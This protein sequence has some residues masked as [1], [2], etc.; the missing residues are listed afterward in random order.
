MLDL[1]PVKAAMYAPT[2]VALRTSSTRRAGSGYRQTSARYYISRKY[3]H[4]VVYGHGLQ[5]HVD[6]ALT[7]E[8]SVRAS[9]S[10]LGGEF[11]PVRHNI[12]APHPHPRRTVAARIN[13]IAN[14]LTPCAYFLIP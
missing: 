2:V 4:R 10:A 9:R 7:R 6:D 12:D 11:N 1:G 13:P 5:A 3:S 14:T 8:P